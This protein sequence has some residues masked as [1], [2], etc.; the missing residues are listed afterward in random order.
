MTNRIHMPRT[1][2]IALALFAQGLAGCSSRPE[3]KDIEAALGNVYQC[4]ALAV[5]G[6]KTIDGEP[7]PQGSY[8]VACD[9]VAD[10]AHSPSAGSRAQS[11]MRAQTICNPSLPAVCRPWSAPPKRNWQ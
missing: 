10:V 11:S 8:G 7:G 4:P 5:K 1:P 6:S 2:A 9:I 3:A